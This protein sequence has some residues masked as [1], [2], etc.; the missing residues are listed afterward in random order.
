MKKILFC[1]LLIIFSG[2]L[3]A[4]VESV[5][6]LWGHEWTVGA[7]ALGMA[8]SFTGIS[9]DCSAL[10][11]NPAGIGQI[12]R[13]TAYAGFSHLS[14]SE[15]A[16]FLGT[17]TSED[18]AFTK[19]NSAGVCVPLPTTRGSLVLGI[20]YHVV[21]DFNRS[22]YVTGFS[23]LPGDSVTYSYNELEEGSLTNTTFGASIEVAPGLFVGGS[24]NF[25]QGSNDYT[26]QMK[27]EDKPF[28]IWTYSRFTGTTYINTSLTGVNFTFGGFFNSNGL[29]SAGGVIVTPVT[30]TGKED[31]EYEEMTYWDDGL[32]TRDSTDSGYWDYKIRSP[33]IFRFGGALKAGPLLI[34]GD[35]EFKNYSQ[36][37]YITEPSKSSENLVQDNLYFRQNFRNVTDYRVGCEFTIPNTTIRL[38]AGY[39]FLASPLKHSKNDRKIIGLGAGVG[40]S[41]Q[42]F[43]DIGY[44]F[45]SWDGQGSDEISNERIEAKKILV[46]MM[47]KIYR[48]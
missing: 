41:D 25:W 1:F 36:I 47:Y 27:D 30:L 42:I 10:Y 8:G 3:S 19:L 14:I 5:P 40:V 44:G 26:W 37:K 12:D 15:S 48:R 23:S 6:F 32:Q 39:G 33:W 4:Q 46:T 45:T 38:R 18:A 29:F 17:T 34:S 28:D 11:Y 43:L 13:I 7:R 21:R 2:V 20:G 35:I 31:W 22:L 16:R 24:I 9:D